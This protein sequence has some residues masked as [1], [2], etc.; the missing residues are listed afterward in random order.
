MALLQHVLPED[1]KKV[2]PKRVG[3]NVILSFS[4]GVI[5]ITALLGGYADYIVS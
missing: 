3:V 1:E 2:S 4:R 5:E